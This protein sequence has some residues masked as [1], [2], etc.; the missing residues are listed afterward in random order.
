M[1]TLAAASGMA[2]VADA[3][4]ASA[5]STADLLLCPVTVPPEA[6]ATWLDR[7]PPQVRPELTNSEVVAAAA[8][9]RGWPSGV[10]YIPTGVGRARFRTNRQPRYLAAISSV[11]VEE[12][13]GSVIGAGAAATAGCAR[14]RKGAKTRSV[15]DLFWRSGAAVAAVVEAGFTDTGVTLGPAVGFEAEP[16]GPTSDVMTA[17]TAAVPVGTGD[18]CSFAG[19]TAACREVA[20]AVEGAACVGAA[21]AFAVF[22]AGAAGALT[23]G[24]ATRLAAEGT[25][26][27]DIGD[28]AGGA[29]TARATGMTAILIA[30]VAAAFTTV[31]AAR[32]GP[33]GPP[34]PPTARARRARASEARVEVLRRT[35]RLTRA[36]RAPR[37]D[38]T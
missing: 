33:G 17:L 5:T 37:G 12:T 10:L 36:R 14:E 30:A 32:A 25:E 35:P 16:A 27:L 31:A 19:A 20:T 26:F 7:Q 8:T 24:T 9:E 4:V 21:A 38:S 11:T 15:T 3:A 23:T 28:F 34:R 13:G 18:A 6:T 22:A 1:A 29:A 2:T